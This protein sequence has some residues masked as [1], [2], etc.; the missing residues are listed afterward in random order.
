VRAR[1]NSL[2]YR[3]SKFVRRNRVAVAAGIAV[4]AALL[5]GLFAARRS[6]RIAEAE[7]LH[8]RIEA[9]SFQSIASFLMDAFLPARPSEDAAW[10]GR[11]RERILAQA[12]RVHRQYAD[13]DHM[14][15]NLLDTLG[16]VCLR[17]DLFDDAESLMREALAIRK[18]AF[19]SRSMEYALSLR[20]LGQLKYQVGEYAEAARLLGE[21]LPLHRSA[22]S[23]THADVAGLA[24]DLAACLRN[25]GRGAE[26]ETLHRESLALRRAKNDGTL[27]VAESLNNLAG[28][29]LGRGEYE[30][31]IT[32]LREALA[33]RNAILGDGHLLTLQTLSNLAGALWRNAE[34]AEAREVMQRA[35]TGYRALGEDGEDGLG[36]VLANLAAMQIADGDLGG[37]ASSLEEALALQQKHLGDDHP[38]VAVTL[39]KL[40]VLDHARHREDEARR[41]WEDVLR[42]RRAAQA[43]PRD[44]AEALY[45]YGVFL[46]DVG[47]CDQATPLV[48]QAIGLH[49]SQDL[50]DPTGLGRAEHVLGNCLSRIGELELA[51]GHLQEAARLLDASPAATPAERSRVHQSLEELDRPAGG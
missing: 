40:A 33:I 16:Q 24:N 37:A 25:L 27:P 15:A 50:E 44:L 4:L 45:G 51:R 6:E 39:A 32:E 5:F 30:L 1:G 17:L 42:I 12:E 2:V 10:L 26:A 9:D 22:E 20:S 36:L 34:I 29:H 38:L 19:G 35:E 23:S 48:E 7:A 21:A 8:A 3:A 14:R 46:S 11:A 47:E 49:H 28:V 13:S 31:A 41:A 43:P 18:Q